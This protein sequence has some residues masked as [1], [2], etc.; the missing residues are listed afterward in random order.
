MFAVQKDD[1]MNFSLE[2][3]LRSI[4]PSSPQPGNLQVD[5]ED[6]IKFSVRLLIPMGQCPYTGKRNINRFTDIL[7]T[8]AKILC[9]DLDDTLT[10]GNVSR[11]RK[12]D[13]LHQY[14]PH[15][16]EIGALFDQL[17]DNHKQIFVV[18]FSDELYSDQGGLPIISK[19]IQ[20]CTSRWEE[21]RTVS[22]YPGYYPCIPE[23]KNLHLHIIADEC[24]ESPENILLIDDNINNII[25]AHNRGYQ[26]M[27]VEHSL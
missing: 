11:L 26:T 25:S 16:S 9:F 19:V 15:A 22:F 5:D 13:D 24:H 20:A 2:E 27:Y 8:T 17:L 10:Q 4:K 12:E 7:Q 6:R 23:N 18:S 1:C 14:L 21:I 3:A